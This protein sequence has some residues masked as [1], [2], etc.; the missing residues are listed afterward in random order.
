MAEYSPESLAQALVQRGGYNPVDAGNASRG[1]RASELAREFLGASTSSTQPSVQ[2]SSDINEL[3]RQ[4]MQLQ[5]QAIQ[6]SVS[7]IQQAT[8]QQVGQLQQQR[9]PLKQRYQNLLESLKS[10]QT[11][12]ITAQQTV[13]SREFGRRGI[14]L[15]SGEFDVALQEKL[16]PVRRA[17]AGQIANVGLEQESALAGLEGQISGLPL[18]SAMQIAQL[19]GGAGQSA[20]NN[21]LSLLQQRQNQEAQQAALAEQR[22]Q[23]ELNR[24]LKLQEFNQVTLP[25]SKAQLAKIAAETKK[26]QSEGGGSLNEQSE[27]QKI[28]SLNLRTDGERA[29]DNLATKSTKGRPSLESFWK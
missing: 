23:D 10:Q 16:S 22:R 1:P 24:A 3:A 29:L 11:E 21:A 17:Y 2:S 14:P 9:E 4:Q 25:Q 19:Q 12:D 20:I 7:A 28:F 8:Q 27:L 6:P 15:S 5:Q 18:Q 13:T 26:L